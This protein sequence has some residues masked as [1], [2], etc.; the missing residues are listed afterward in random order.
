MKVWCNYWEKMTG[1]GDSFSKCANDGLVRDSA[2]KNDLLIK[3]K[4]R[5]T[6]GGDSKRKTRK[7]VGKFNSARRTWSK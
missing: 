3:G 1:P 5:V 2:K 6:L 7:N 4:E